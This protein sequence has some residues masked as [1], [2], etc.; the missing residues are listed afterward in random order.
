[1]FLRKPIDHDCQP[2]SKLGAGR[3]HFFKTGIGACAI[4]ALPSVCASTMNMGERQL[5]FL[6]LHTGERVRSTYWAEGSYVPEAL[7]AIENVLRDHR[8]GE[9]RAIDTHLLDV[10]QLLHGQMGARKEFHVISAYR[11]PETNAVLAAR[12]NR[13]VKQSLHMHGKAIDIRLPECSLADLREAALSLKVGG[14]GYYPESN[15]IHVDTGH[16]RFW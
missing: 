14:V 4:F 3:R 9:M 5:A 7:R 11:S 6:N 16:V 13:V 10:L 8:T 2:L 12:S 15:F 1:M